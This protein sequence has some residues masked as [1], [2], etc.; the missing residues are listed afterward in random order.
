MA[1][2]LD[3]LAPTIQPVAIEWQDNRGPRSHAGKMLRP[4]IVSCI[5]RLPSNLNR[6]DAIIWRSY[7]DGNSHT[8]KLPTFLRE[9]LADETTYAGVYVN[10]EQGSLEVL[11]ETGFEILITNITIDNDIWA[12]VN[13]LLDAS[14][15]QITDNNGD[16]I[17]VE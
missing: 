12:G 1:V 3:G 4:A 14:G 7:D 2:E 5:L 13:L 15:Q 17:Y 9:Y 16:A 8:I 11:Q 6:D 10:V